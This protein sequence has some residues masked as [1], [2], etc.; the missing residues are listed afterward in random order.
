MLPKLL[1]KELIE[2]PESKH[3][4]DVRRT[5]DPKYCKYHRII[6]HPIE[7]C[8]ALRIQVMQL[9]KKGKTTLGKGD[10]EEAD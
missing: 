4:K 1:E 9:T 8:N 6:S 7:K 3:P 2:L 5:N 10:T